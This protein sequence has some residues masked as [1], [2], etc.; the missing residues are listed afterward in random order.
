[1]MTKP[2]GSLVFDKARLL[3]MF[4]D[5]RTATEA[6]AMSKFRNYN[7]LSDTAPLNSK[8]QKT[9]TQFH[10]RFAESRMWDKVVDLVRTSSSKV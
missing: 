9:F 3:Q 5:A 4:N 7:G 1:M 6:E 10:K 2:S 8:M